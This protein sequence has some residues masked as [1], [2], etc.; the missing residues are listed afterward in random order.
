MLRRM[1]QTDER[2]AAKIEMVNAVK[3]IV[4]VVCNLGNCMTTTKKSTTK[5]PKA[6]AKSSSKKPVRLGARATPAPAAA[7]PTEA[8]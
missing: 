5:V 3:T 4:D 2:I 6:T 7:E 1:H 8:V